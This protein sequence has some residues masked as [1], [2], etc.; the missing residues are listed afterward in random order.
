MSFLLLDTLAWHLVAAELEVLERSIVSLHP[1]NTTVGCRWFYKAKFHADGSLER[2][3]ARLVAKG[4]TQQEGISYLDIFLRLR[5][6]LL[7]ELYWL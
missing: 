5:S 1:G 2:Y 6:L 3:N 7:F 4:Y